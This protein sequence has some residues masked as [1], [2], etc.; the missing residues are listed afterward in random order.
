VV[1]NHKDKGCAFKDFILD[2][3][4]KVKDPARAEGKD[5][6][7]DNEPLYTMSTAPTTQTALRLNEFDVRI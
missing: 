7:G 3:I 4:Q 5:G 6:S 1:E 2:C